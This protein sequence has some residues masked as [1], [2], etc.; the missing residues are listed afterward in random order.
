MLKKV[1]FRYVS[2]CDHRM[3]YLDNTFIF[4]QL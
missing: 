3:S 4:M 2:F 1:S